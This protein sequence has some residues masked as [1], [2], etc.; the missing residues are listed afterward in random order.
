MEKLV[1]LLNKYNWID[2]FWIDEYDDSNWNCSCFICRWDGTECFVN[3]RIISKRFW[4]IK[5]LVDKNMIDLF[6]L[7]KKFEEIWFF[8]WVANRIVMLLSISDTPIDDLISY[9]K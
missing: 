4:F 6:K 2:T 8:W 7:P 1:K 9:L 3:E 5:R